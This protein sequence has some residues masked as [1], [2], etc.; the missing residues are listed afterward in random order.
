MNIG[1]D[2]E[3]GGMRIKVWGKSKIPD[4]PKCDVPGVILP[5]SVYMSTLEKQT[6]AWL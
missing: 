3:H 6:K 4:T 5:K 1:E 2:G